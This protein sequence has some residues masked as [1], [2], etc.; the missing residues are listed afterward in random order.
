MDESR[1]ARLQAELEVALQKRRRLDAA[2]EYMQEELRGAVSVPSPT[3]DGG[4]GGTPDG[5]TPSAATDPAQVV[6]AGAFYGMSGPKAAKALLQNFDRSRPLTTDEIFDAIVKG[7][8][9]KVSSK[10]VLYRS[11]FRDAAF[12]KVGRG[13]WG[14]AEWYPPG[15]RKAAKA[16]AEKEAA[17]LGLDDTNTV[18]AQE[19]PGETPTPNGGPAGAA[20]A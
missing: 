18:E 4:G 17:E 6:T 14:L 8:C 2:I 16:D 3:P 1:Q 11:L 5:G 7:G 20:V 9:T 13:V 15:A 10:D 19:T 12:L